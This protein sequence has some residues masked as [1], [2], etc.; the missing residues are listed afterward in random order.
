M[1]GGS[2]PPPL[3]PWREAQ[4]DA[5][6]SAVLLTAGTSFSR[7]SKLCSSH[8]LGRGGSLSASSLGAASLQVFHHST[9]FG[10]ATCQACPSAWKG[11]GKLLLSLSFVPGTVLNMSLGKLGLIKP[12]E[13]HSMLVIYGC[14]TNHS[15]FRGLKHHLSPLHFC[16][17][18]T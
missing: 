3:P 8:G 14:I 2:L 13:R 11:E 18:G 5:F 17:S 16:G 15:K 4:A 10:R 12:R 6:R 1:A 7:G 9:L